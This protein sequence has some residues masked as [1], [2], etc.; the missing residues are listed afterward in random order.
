M[1]DVVGRL[2]A[3]CGVQD[4]GQLTRCA[5]LRFIDRDVVFATRP[6]DFETSAGLMSDTKR[7]LL[8]ISGGL[9][10]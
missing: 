5:S 3:A 9:Y 6:A 1:A 7:M 8:G 10:R 4:P 2:H